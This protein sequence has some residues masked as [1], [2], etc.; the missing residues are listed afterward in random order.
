M[1][2][3]Y[4]RIGIHENITEMYNDLKIFSKYI[5]LLFH[6]FACFSTVECTQN[7]THTKQEFSY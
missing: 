4:Y 3:L 6:L 2:H 1:K 5:I 7:L